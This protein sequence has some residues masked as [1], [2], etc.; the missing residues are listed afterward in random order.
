MKDFEESD[1]TCYVKKYKGEDFRIFVCAEKKEVF[2]D[3]KVEH[4]FYTHDGAE[5]VARLVSK[6]WQHEG[7]ESVIKQLK[8]STKDNRSIPGLLLD[9]LAK[10]T[11]RGKK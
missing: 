5:C 6:L 11:E 10:D 2:L 8:K 3:G 7:I 1:C 4:D 9:V